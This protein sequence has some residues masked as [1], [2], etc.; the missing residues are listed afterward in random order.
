MEE[1]LQKKKYHILILDELAV[2]LNLG[3]LPIEKVINFLIQKDDALHVIITGRD[4]PPELIKMADIVT[5]MKEVK[6]I[7]KEGVVAIQGLD[8]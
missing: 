7:Y 6:H 8:Y 5:E 3:L 4:V 2:V 1:M